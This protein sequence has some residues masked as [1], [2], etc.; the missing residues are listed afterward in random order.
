[1][2]NSFYVVFF[3]KGYSMKSHESDVKQINQALNELIQ[4]ATQLRDLSL[5]VISEDELLPL[6]KRQEVLLHQLETIDQQ[7]QRDLLDS[8]SK[9]NI[10]QQ[11][12]IFKKL[13]QEFIQNLNSSHGLIQFEMENLSNEEEIDETE[14]EENEEK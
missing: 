2:D 11:L 13:N 9:E 4:V 12:Q 3:E 8:Q 6:Q 5:K 1:M 14:S 10:H 7:I